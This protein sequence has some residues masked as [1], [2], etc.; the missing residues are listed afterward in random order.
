MMKHKV[1]M[2][3]TNINIGPL[4]GAETLFLVGYCPFPPVAQW[5]WI[6]FSQCLQ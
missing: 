2:L 6:Q 4:H 5:S 3:Y 1:D